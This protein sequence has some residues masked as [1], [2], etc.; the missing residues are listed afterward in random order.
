MSNV[1]RLADRRWRR[2]RSEH[3]R[4]LAGLER[5]IR[6]HPAGGARVRTREARRRNVTLVPLDGD[7]GDAA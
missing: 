4:T 6:A 2:M 3:A 7:R 1:F 5:S